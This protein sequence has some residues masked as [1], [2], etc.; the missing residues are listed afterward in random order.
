MAND[1]GNDRSK[2]IEG[3]QDVVVAQRRPDPSQPPMTGLTLNGFLGDS[4][5]AG[6]RRLYF[7]MNLDYYIEFAIADVVQTSQIPAE[8]P[9]FVGAEATQ[10]LLKKDA[11]V[12]YTRTSK[13]RP[14]DE[15][16]LDI[17][18]CPPGLFCLFRTY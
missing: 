17:I 12:A 7:T 4:D 9:P 16:D 15:F 8:Q 6:Q 2:D 18:P 13:V 5:R 10:I 3:P 1:A 11:H 14:P